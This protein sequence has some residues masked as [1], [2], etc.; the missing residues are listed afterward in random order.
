MRSCIQWSV[1]SLAVQRGRY[2]A[3]EAEAATCLP[4]GEDLFSLSLSGLSNR[5]HC[6][7]LLVPLISTLKSHSQ[8]QKFAFGCSWILSSSSTRGTYRSGGQ[9]SLVKV[10]ICASGFQQAA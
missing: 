4:L 10:L 9:L 1:E 6:H 8:N 7:P 2:D 3:V 5:R